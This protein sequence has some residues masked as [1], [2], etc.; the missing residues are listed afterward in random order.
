MA[1]YLPN[2][3]SNGKVQIAYILQAP[4]VR[5]HNWPGDALFSNEKTAMSYS[6]HS[7]V[8]GAASSLDRV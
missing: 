6:S 1:T 3:N 7:Y 4:T 2:A 8:A 5:C